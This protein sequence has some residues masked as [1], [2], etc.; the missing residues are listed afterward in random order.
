MNQ[1]EIDEI[2]N[3][4]SQKFND[5]L[6]GIV[7]MLVRKKIGKFQSFQAESLPDS[8]RTCSVEEL[9]N[10]VQEALESGKLKL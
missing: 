1:K 5:D 4:I 10:I 6:P 8:L 3:H 2:L 9:I 7:K